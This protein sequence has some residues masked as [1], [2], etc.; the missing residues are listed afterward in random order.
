MSAGSWIAV[1]VLVQTCH[2]AVTASIGAVMA[3]DKVDQGSLRQLKRRGVQRGDAQ[4]AC[5]RQASLTM[6]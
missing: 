4:S 6:W 2:Q 5:R 3:I 1:R